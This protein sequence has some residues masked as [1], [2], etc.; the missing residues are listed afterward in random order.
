MCIFHLIIISNKSN[1]LVT[2]IALETYLSVKL[3]LAIL[4]FFSSCYSKY[5]IPFFTVVFQ[6]YRNIRMCV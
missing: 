6:F 1:K 2:P 4:S 3:F 5:T